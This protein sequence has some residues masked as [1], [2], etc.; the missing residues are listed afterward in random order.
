[1]AG[2]PDAKSQAAI[3]PGQEALGH[4]LCTNRSSRQVCAPCGQLLWI[5][6]WR[7]LQTDCHACTLADRTV[8][9]QQ[10]QKHVSRRRSPVLGA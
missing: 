7:V 6:E 8:Q 9:Q 10:Q 2:S 1:M 5:Q 4:W 3:A